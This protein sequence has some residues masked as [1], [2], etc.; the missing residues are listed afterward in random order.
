MPIVTTREERR[1]LERANAKLPRDLVEWRR[2]D[3]PPTAQ[4]ARVSPIRVFR[5]R[6]FLVQEF[7]EPAPAIARLSINRTTLDGQRWKD[8]ITWDDL[9]SI[10]NQIGYASY[11]A[12]E[13][14]PPA[15]DVVNVANIRHLWVLNEPLSFQ[16]K[17]GDGR[18]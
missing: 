4:A 9:Q 2:E 7:A 6:D 11:T 3:W 14:Y 12:I 18:G 1:V 10:K 15:V 13:V 17:R 8:G 16:W 5:S